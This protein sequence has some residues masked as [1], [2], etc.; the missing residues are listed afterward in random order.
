M[1][2]CLALAACGFAQS[3]TNVPFT[4]KPVEA[5]VPAY[6]VKPDLS[7]VANR[8]ILPKLTSD[9]KKALARNGFV[10]RPTAEE[11]LFYIYE[12][13]AYKK[14]GSFV[15]TDSVLHTYHIF[16]DFTLRYLEKERLSPAAVQLS[17]LM[18]NTNLAALKGQHPAEIKAA[19]G[20]NVVFFAVPLEL[21]GKK[22]SLPATQRKQVNAEIARI[23]A[24]K[25]RSTAITG[26]Q[27]DY[28]QFVPRGHYTRSKQFEQYFRAM[29]WYGL[30]PMRLETVKRHIDKPATLQ[31]LIITDQLMGSTKARTLWQQLYDPTVF[32]VGK[33]DDLSY[34]NY[35]AI[36]KRIF[37]K[38]NLNRFNNGTKLEQF[39][40]LAMKELA[41]PGIENFTA[42][43]GTQ[44]KQFR[45]M[46]QRFIPDS[47]IL[48]ELTFPKVGTVGSARLF[49][50]GLDVFAVMGSPRAAQLLDTTYRQTKYA[51]YLKQR[52]AM[53]LEISKLKNKDWQQNLYYG[54]MYS[55][56]PLL[57]PRPAGYPAFMRN[58]AWQEKSLV[59]ALGSW[60]EL[61][62]D[63]ILYAKQSVAECGE[64]GD[65][66]PPV[67]G[68]VE[69]EVGVYERLSW[70]LKLNK[71]GLQQRKLIT[72]KDEL[73]GSFDEFVELTD[74]LAK[75]SRK[76]LLNQPLSR[77]E[78]RALEKY[79]GHLE[80]L[81]LSASTLGIHD[82]IRDWWQLENKTDRRMGL[83]ADVHTS[84]G[85]VLEEAVGNAAEIWVVVPIQGKLRLTRGATFTYYEFQHPASDRMTD[86]AWQ[87]RLIKGK[88]PAMPGWMHSYMLG[89]ARKTPVPTEQLDDGGT[90]C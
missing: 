74:F 47:R 6:T 17:T 87:Q 69:P 37:G 10:A 71:K 14:I 43:E 48:Q 72:G 24:H 15:T 8:K 76:E 60:T 9:Q 51:N 32:Y 27:I 55:L 19:I 88:V 42:N 83:V 20:R 11:Q 12:N 52:H 1:L 40:A 61:R 85:T 67:L 33:A 25:G 70:L 78:L 50:M 81:M 77:E 38:G 21:Q 54:W 90:G 35:N 26:T 39:H 84:Q 18:L 13:N 41:G 16:Y 36:S 30:V 68:Y 86:E 31:A 64:G 89:P 65:E 63:T 29:M 5:K 23:M 46:G 28:S 53:R 34:Y 66:P 2:F 49:P 62:H 75:A 59:T 79:G 82:G 56:Q 58:T 3:F 44:G 73:G 22:I 7:N 45:F 4:P 80:R 57:P